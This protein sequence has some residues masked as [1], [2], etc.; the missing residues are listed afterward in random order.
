V[1]ERLDDVVGGDRDVGRPLLQQ[2][3]ARRHHAPRRPPDRILVGRR[4]VV[5]EQL[6]G[7]IYKVD[8]H[9]RMPTPRATARLWEGG[10][11]MEHPDAPVGNSLK[12]TLVERERRFLLGAVPA[13]P[14]VRRAEITDRYLQGTR[15]RLRQTV[16]TTAAG[17]TTVRKL[18]QKIPDP[19]GGPG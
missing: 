18:T 12:Y 11:A 15:L 16:E 7:A 14:C 5:S 17:T 9:P 2:H 10:R 8:Q 3:Q 19:A 1:P 6:V 4:V 13:G